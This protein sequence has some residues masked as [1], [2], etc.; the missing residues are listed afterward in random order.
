MQHCLLH[1]FVHFSIKM[2][3]TDRAKDSYYSHSS[4]LGARIS[5]ATSANL[6]GPN[7]VLNGEIVDYINKNPQKIDMAI[8][9]LCARMRN[10]NPKVQLMTLALVD[11]CV[12]RCCRDFLDACE[13]PMMVKELTR[14][15]T[16]SAAGAHVL[17]QK[18]CIQLLW[19]WRCSFMSSNSPYTYFSRLVDRLERGG[20]PFPTGTPQCFSL[21]HLHRIGGFGNDSNSMSMTSQRRSNGRVSKGAY[22]LSPT[23]SSRMCENDTIVASSSHAQQTSSTFHGMCNPTV[24]FEPSSLIQDIEQD[25]VTTDNTVSIVVSMLTSSPTTSEYDIIDSLLHDLTTIQSKMMDLMRDMTDEGVMQR[26]L[27]CNDMINNAINMKQRAV[28]AEP[29]PSRQQQQEV[30]LI[31]LDDT[32]PLIREISQPATPWPVNNI[33]PVVKQRGYAED[34][35]YP[36]EQ[37]DPFAELA[38]RAHNTM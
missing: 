8:S 12:R 29:P 5:Q 32:A 38:A 28:F 30:T 31:D 9:H 10:N 18:K 1:T 4:T 37:D 7:I 27:S 22:Y 2:S 21:D 25:L 13:K 17:V 6:I 19:E 24:M 16:I 34:A 14:L 3:I 11:A 33:T 15:V 35:P 20:V 23:E 26:M 36:D